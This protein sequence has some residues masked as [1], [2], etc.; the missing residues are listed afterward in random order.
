MFLFNK[1][2]WQLNISLFTNIYKV[3][4][5]LLVC[6]IEIFGIAGLDGLQDSFML[7]D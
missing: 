4:E 6:G 7:S 2:N 3:K 5:N 1:T